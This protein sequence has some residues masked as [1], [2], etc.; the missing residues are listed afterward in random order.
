MKGR[1]FV[2]WK[3]EKGKEVLSMGREE[4]KKGEK[5]EDR[6]LSERSQKEK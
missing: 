6:K 5:R 1:E 3:R 2:G 4:G